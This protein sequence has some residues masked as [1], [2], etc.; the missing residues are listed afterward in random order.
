V[1]GYGATLEVVGSMP[2]GSCVFR[3]E[4]AEDLTIRGLSIVGPGGGP[5]GAS[6]VALFG[7]TAVRIE[8]VTLSGLPAIGLR[9]GADAT[10]QP[11]RD[12]TIEACSVVDCA[13]GCIVL[14]GTEQVAI[15]ACTLGARATT[16]PRPVY[17]LGISSSPYPNR[18]VVMGS[19][20]VGGC[21]VGVDCIGAGTVDLSLLTGT[22]A[23]NGLGARLRGDGVIVVANSLHRCEGAAITAL[24]SRI[25]LEANSVNHGGGGIGVSGSDVLVRANL[26]Y[27]C[28]AGLTTPAGAVVDHNMVGGREV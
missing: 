8:E 2:S 11:T 17:G 14:V 25:R 15:A 16:G 23:E 10:G 5:S 28:A 7:C 26:I 6:G 22:F 27:N 3:A 13:A 4:R 12:V 20:H 1:Q 21:A 24:G 9:I 18:T 19:S